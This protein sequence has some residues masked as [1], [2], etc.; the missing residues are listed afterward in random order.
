M[1]K[2]RDKV[3]LLFSDWTAKAGLVL[4]SPYLVA[5]ALA[6]AARSVNQKRNV[7]VLCLV[8]SIFT[9]DVN[10]LAHFG[11][12]ITY[13]ILNLHYLYLIYEYFIPE[14]E[15]LKIGEDNYH[16]EDH[17]Q[18]GK[19]K[20]FLFLTRLLPALKKQL[21][22]EAIL[23]GNFGYVDQQEFARACVA[24]NIP[25]IVLHKEGMALPGSLD[26][27]AEIYKKRKFIGK[28]LLLYNDNM[29]QAMLNM[30]LEGADE[31]NMKVVGIPRMDYYFRCS[32][33]KKDGKQITF[34]S[35]FPEEK[36]FWLLSDK[37]DLGQALSRS[38]DF[39]RWL[40]NI[41]L[42]HKEVKLVIK[43]KFAPHYV[44]YVQNI[45]DKYFKDEKLD[46]I[47]VTNSLKPT[48]LVI[49]SDVVIGFNSTVL[50]EGL[51][52]KKTII[53][54]FFGDL[55]KEKAW[56]YF[57]DHA[58]L[59]NYATSEQELENMIFNAKSL[60]AELQSDKDKFLAGFVSNPDG[61]ACLRVEQE[62]LASIDRRY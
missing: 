20:Y 33:P 36:F 1:T 55:I 2:I 37:E 51:A 13:K 39:L 49:G 14:S 23:A 53:T 26:K 27:V 34:F 8:R 60:G 17:G 35:F 18:A 21:G 5:L 46:N 25:F 24:L 45:L 16:R 22:V 4:D 12:E 7:G 6:V 30:Q 10:A 61:N 15:R 62:I 47:I 48:D 52:A 32:A 59:V 44:D 31:S 57:P 50:I 43:T 42:R 41:A 56:D 9:E 58:G 28:K 29:K 19:E 38:E 11:S 40:V 3:K 54:P